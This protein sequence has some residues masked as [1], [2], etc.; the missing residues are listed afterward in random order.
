METRQLGRVPGHVPRKG[1]P[2]ATCGPRAPFCVGA[3]QRVTRAKATGHDRKEEVKSKP[4]GVLQW[5]SEGISKKKSP[6]NERL[7]EEDTDIACIQETHPQKISGSLIGAIRHSKR[8]ERRDTDVCTDP[9][10]RTTR[11]QNRALLTLAARLRSLEETLPMQKQQ[12]R[13]YNV[14]FQPN[15]Q[16]FLDN[17]Q[18][19][20]ASW[21]KNASVLQALKD[22]TM[23]QSARKKKTRPK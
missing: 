23:T 19:Y 15:Q 5:G 16:F 21:K 20:N 3:R 12:I 8:T 10:I 6:F 7:H 14:Y 9:G 1:P 11:L 4:L 13:I 2:H 18:I 22:A 17:M